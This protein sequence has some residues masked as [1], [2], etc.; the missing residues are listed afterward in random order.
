MAHQS[1]L[2]SA[3]T[4]SGSSTPRKQRPVDG[5]V[6]IEQAWQKVD[7]SNAHD[8]LEWAAVEGG[9]DP[10]E[11]ECVVCAKTFRSEAAWDSHERSK[12]HLKEVERVK[13][14]ML[15]EDEEFELDG[16]IDVE[17]FGVEE[18]SESGMPPTSSSHPV[19]RSPSPPP[20]PHSPANTSPP[21]LSGPEEE[22]VKPRSKQKRSHKTGGKVTLEPL[23][24]TEQNA[25]TLT[26]MDIVGM[27]SGAVPDTD[28]QTEQTKREKR[29][30]RQAKKAEANEGATSEKMVG[31][32][33]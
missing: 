20:I 12:K 10:E 28:G 32:A 27:P 13:K 30:A 33:S 21:A 19:A 31:F 5:P 4:A 18:G 14:Q 26:D 17:V 15:D 24:D 22:D 23:T 9:E 7:H 3:A 6:Y 11:W 25:R 8:D 2:A 29:R 1:S 16:D